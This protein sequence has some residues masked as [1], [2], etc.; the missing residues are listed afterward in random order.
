[1]PFYSNEDKFH[2][3]QLDCSP[4]SQYK[5]RINGIHSD[6]LSAAIFEKRNVFDIEPRYTQSL[7]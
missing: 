3:K 2:L 4:D 7:E 1:M 5:L 6:L